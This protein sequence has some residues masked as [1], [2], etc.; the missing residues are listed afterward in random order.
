MA[1]SSSITSFIS[2]P[3]KEIVHVFKSAVNLFV[4]ISAKP[5]LRFLNLSQYLRRQATV[6][7]LVQQKL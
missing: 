5:L 6:K 3:K 7:D 2:V 1:D 4:G